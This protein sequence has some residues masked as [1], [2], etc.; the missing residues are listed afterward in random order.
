MR[1]SIKIVAAVVAAVVCLAQAGIANAAEIKVLGAF[2]MQS[3]LDD[4]GP[5][6]ERATGH[7]LAI[8]FATG[9]R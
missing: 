2:G 4:L 5:K 1:K 7:K 9:A 8:S 6:F 3:V